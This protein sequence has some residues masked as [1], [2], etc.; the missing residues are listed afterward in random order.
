MIPAVF[1][2]LEC[3]ATASGPVSFAE[4]REHTGAAPATLSRLLGKL[5]DCSYV[6]KV[7]HGSYQVGPNLISLS[8][9]VMENAAAY[10]F[11]PLL[12]ELAEATGQNAELY[13]LTSNGPVFLACVSGGSE[14]RITL[15][16][17]YHIRNPL[18]HPAGAF[19]FLR[20]PDAL[21]RWAGEIEGRHRWDLAEWRRT[22][23][24]AR[25][26]RFVIHRGVTRPELARAAVATP[27]SGFVVCLSGLVGDFPPAR[28]ESLRRRMLR[29]VRRFER[30]TSPSPA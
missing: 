15:T 20:Y 2:I 22:V 14:L 25:R 26:R 29:T 3:L 16:P 11:R 9:L 24:G 19:Y 6:R 21:D 18:R 28:D 13:T 27:E 7:A 8:T 23:E 12:R 1:P 4:L 10:A 5:V 17:G 30:Q